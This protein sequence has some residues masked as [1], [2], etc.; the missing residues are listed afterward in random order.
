M[1][2]FHRV[3]APDRGMEA[4]GRKGGGPADRWSQWSAIL[5]RTVHAARPLPRRPCLPFPPGRS[6]GLRISLPACAFPS[7]PCMTVALMQAFVP[8]H[9]CGP[10]PDSHRTS[11]SPEGARFFCFQDLY[12]GLRSHVNKKLAARLRP[13]GLPGVR[14]AASPRRDPKGADTP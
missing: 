4:A 9:G 14:I 3:S 10:A 12:M 6:P 2:A 13:R 7:R 5:P 1:P 11:R 8:A